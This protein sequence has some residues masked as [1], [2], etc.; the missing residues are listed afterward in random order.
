MPPHRIGKE[1][2]ERLVRAEEDF[3]GGLAEEG[4]CEH[5][6]TTERGS[7]LRIVNDRS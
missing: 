1:C 7:S 2:R 6:K 5:K 4:I 3:V